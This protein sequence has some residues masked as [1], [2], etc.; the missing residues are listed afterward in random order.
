MEWFIID[1]YVETRVIWLHLTTFRHKSV[2]FIG[3]L[4]IV[5]FIGSLPAAAHHQQQCTQLKGCRMGAK[6]THVMTMV[7]MLMMFMMMIMMIVLE[8]TTI[9]RGWFACM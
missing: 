9:L 2:S 5:L 7:M 4:K 1:K 8:L 6:G 3:S